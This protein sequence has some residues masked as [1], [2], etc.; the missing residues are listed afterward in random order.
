[1]Q[2][3][4]IPDAASQAYRKTRRRI[5]PFVFILYIIAY[6]DRA[7]VAFASAAMRADLGFSEAVF[8]FGAGVFFAGY[9]LLEIPG[10]LIVERWS[11]R[12][13]IARILISWGACGVAVG[14]VGSAY[15]FY[16]AR[17]LLGMAEAGFFPGVVVYLT[18]W[19]RAK[20]RAGALAALALAA[21]A[22][23]VVGAPLS[24]LILNMHSF[25]LPGWRWMFILEGLPAIVL[26]AVT[27]VYMTD[28]PHQAA[29]LRP[30]ERDWLTAALAQEQTAKP[31]AARVRW[32]EGLRDHNVLRLTAAHFCANLAGYGFIIWLPNT[33][34]AGLRLPP[35]LTTAVTAL[36][37]IAAMI[38]MV[39]VARSSDRSGERRYH[40]ATVF[41]CA[42]LFL[43][44][45][46]FPDQPRVLSVIWVVFTGAA[47]YS[48]ITPF[49]V[50]P[51]ILLGESAAA[52]SI[53]LINAVGNF[54]GFAGPFLVGYL[55]SCKWP[56]AAAAATLSLGYVAA[57]ALTFSVQPPKAARLAC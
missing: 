38:A 45:S 49:W 36:P 33:L 6:L 54:G 50:L 32:T 42:A 5:L 35:S 46:S 47:A 21:P 57:A 28:W 7:N 16:T 22:S 11:A 29:W 40:A 56:P 26:G 12:R 52:A 43:A 27:L 1:M 44:L 20:D 41:L 2:A 39:L 55:L 31:L 51:T 53:G 48:W 24:A 17:F 15:Q 34:A 8:G 14:F 3:A 4:T 13:W 10:A 30:A 19:F 18:H 23:L 9:V 37:F 25:E